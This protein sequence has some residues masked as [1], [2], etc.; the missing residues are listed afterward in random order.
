VAKKR[1]L[2]YGIYDLF[3]V[4]FANMDKLKRMRAILDE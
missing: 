3:Q 1:K 2:E 4:N